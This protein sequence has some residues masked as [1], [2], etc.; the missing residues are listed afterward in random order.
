M[1]CICEK[2]LLIFIIEIICIGLKDSQF[3]TV[4]MFDKK[5]WGL[6]L[7][8][9]IDTLSMK[10]CSSFRQESC[11]CYKDPGLIQN[12]KLYIGISAGNC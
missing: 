11:T 9:T 7:K 4:N 8:K 12:I 1:G 10:N 2:F 5:A 3:G 6:L